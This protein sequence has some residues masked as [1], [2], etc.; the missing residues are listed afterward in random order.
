MKIKTGILALALSLAINPLIPHA[1][2]PNVSST[3]LTE[4]LEKVASYDEDRKGVILYFLKGSFIDDRGIDSL[5]SSVTGLL[6]ADERAALEKRHIYT[7][8][9]SRS[10]ESLKGWSQSDRMKLLSYVEKNEMDKVKE[11]LGI[12]EEIPPNNVGI[13]GGGGGAPAAPVTAV[14]I[15]EN[16]LPPAPALGLNPADQLNH[17]KANFRDVENHWARKSIE[18]MVAAGIVS[19]MSQDRFEP[20]SRITRSQMIT[21]IINSLKIDTNIEGTIPFTDVVEGTWYYHPIKTSYQHNLVKGVSASSFAP[22]K[23]ITR[24]E[25]IIM[26]MNAVKDQNLSITP[27]LSRDI[28]RFSDNGKISGWAKE[29]VERAYQLGMISG[30]SETL[31]DPKGTATRAEAVTIIEKVYNLLQNK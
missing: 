7:E 2:E 30:K 31:L 8:D 14:P 23:P 10:L 13:G 19:G 3:A 18:N 1:Q 28:H 17:V 24:E 12:K 21:L 26:I 6:D 20:E 11:M 5:I 16:Q 4:V 25:M 9:I 15:P 27:D 29:S 22:N